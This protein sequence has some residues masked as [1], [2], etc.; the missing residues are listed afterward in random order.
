MLNFI[1][2]NETISAKC[3]IQPKNY[4][5][6]LDNENGQ[7]LSKNFGNLKSL[8]P[9]SKLIGFSTSDVVN[10]SLSEKVIPQNKIEKGDLILLVDSEAAKTDLAKLSYSYQIAAEK[11]KLAKSPKEQEP[12]IESA[13]TNLQIAKAEKDFAEKTFEREKQLFQKNLAS[14][15]NYDALAF[16]L[17]A[18]ELN[19]KQAKADLEEKRLAKKP[20]EIKI[21]SLEVDKINKEIE[22][23]KTYQTIG[24][25]YSPISGIVTDVKNGT[26]LCKI[27]NV[28]T[29]LAEVFIPQK[30]LGKVQNQ[31]KVILKFEPFPNKI[32]ECKVKEINYKIVETDF[33]PYFIAKAE[34]PNPENILKLEMLGF[35]E[36]EIGRTTVLQAFLGG[37]Y[38]KISLTTWW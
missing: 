32:F 18:K 35:A 29:L 16:S 9:F 11:L 17:Q 27:V 30:M 31:N 20:E 1:P 28:D 6:L 36:V 26:T 25:I 3:L 38:S 19:L 12:T 10:F 8:E 33:G 22:I 15:E 2:F 7:I 34:V 5:V 37:S 13:E 21:A 4:W 24:N 14:I 23:L